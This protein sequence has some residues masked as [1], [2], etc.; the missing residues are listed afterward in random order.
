MTI[1]QFI[2]QALAEDTGSGDHTSLACIDAEQNGKAILK[3]KDSG[4]LAGVELAELIFGQVDSR[5]EVKK[6]IDDGN[7]IKPGDVAF[8]I[9][10]YEQ[11]ILLA[12]RLMLN[13]MQRMSGIATI[14]RK[15][16]NAVAGTK[17][18]ILDTR[19]TTPLNREIEKWAVRI[20]GG[21]NHRKGL[22]D[23]ILIKDNHIDYCGG[24]KPALEKV[25][26][27]LESKDLKLQIEIETRNLDEVKQVCETG[28]VN[29]IMLDN[30]TPDQLAEAIKFIDGKFE[31]E[32]SGGI[33]LNSVRTYAETGVDFIS[34][35]A[36]THGA[37]SLDLSLKAVK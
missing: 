3:V 27:Y 24:I 17:A 4:I 25:K 5:I 21:Y 23:M 12:E 18:K 37:I 36:L 28:N 13:C 2:Y 34:V 6:F 10:G 16:V 8:E 29:R 31:T 1:S 15:Y 22:Y 11:K 19:K 7:E 32:A 9:E 33:K 30:F 35:G 20:G 14:T 26:E